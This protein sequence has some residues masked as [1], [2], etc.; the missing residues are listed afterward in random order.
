MGDIMFAVLAEPG[1]GLGSVT[2][3]E[4]DIEALTAATEG[5]HILMRSRYII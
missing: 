2:L 1:K 5:T 4:H 3:A